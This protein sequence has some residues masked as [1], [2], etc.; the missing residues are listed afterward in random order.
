[1]P[2]IKSQAKKRV[3]VSAG[4]KDSVKTRRDAGGVIGTNAPSSPILQQNPDVKQSADDLVAAN[5]SLTAKDI[6]VKAL[7]SELSTERGALVNLTVDWDAHYDVFVS[8]ARKYC[9]T[10]EDAKGLGLAAVGQ[11]IYALAMPIG[12]SAIWD[13]K[14]S[15][16]RVRV[17]RAPGLRAVRLEISPD[18]ITATSFKEIAGDGAT[19][20]LAGFLPGTYWIRAASVRSRERSEFTTPVSVI[21]K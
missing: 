12:V 8:T 16:L 20:A 19:A 4:A 21:V 3:R 6:Q 14:S 1:M 15:L 17:V 2:Y 18:P 5:A 11:A 9:K 13:V 7:E 10:D